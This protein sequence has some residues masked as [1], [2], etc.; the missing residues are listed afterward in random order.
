M[1]VFPLLND[2]LVFPDAAGVILGT[3]NDGVT[4]VVKSTGED[5]VFM[6]REYLEF[7]ASI[8]LPHSAGLVYTRCYNFVALGV[9]LDLTNFILVTL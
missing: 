7:C 3:S 8:S 2:S 4:L 1:L 5:I 6:T 9:E